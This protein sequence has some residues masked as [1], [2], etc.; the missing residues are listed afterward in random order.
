VE[1]REMR[2]L[3]QAQLAAKAG[4]PAAAISHFETG[5][6]KPSFESLVKLAEALSVTV[7][8]L[9]GRE[10][11]PSAAGEEAAALFRD[12][13]KASAADRE[14]IRD[15]LKTRQGKQGKEGP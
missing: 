6:R 1:A 13:D 3:T 8:Y 14:F 15:L 4:L 12:L 11:D 10:I 5:G 7:D 2:K 9:L